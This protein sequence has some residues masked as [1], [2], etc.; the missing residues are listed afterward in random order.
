MCNSTVTKFID[1]GTKEGEERS[2]RSVDFLFSNIDIRPNN[3]S[4]KFKFFASSRET[5]SIYK[6]GWISVERIVNQDV[7]IY[8]Q[9]Q[10]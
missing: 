9:S 3:P 2:E 4:N 1:A 6:L 5:L 7:S 8:F 10:A